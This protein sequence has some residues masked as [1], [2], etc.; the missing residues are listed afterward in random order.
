MLDSIQG[1]SN[2]SPKAFSPL[3]SVKTETLA[4][5]ETTVSLAEIAAQHLSKDNDLRSFKTVHSGGT[6]TLYLGLQDQSSVLFSLLPPS[7]PECSL[8]SPQATISQQ[9]PGVNVDV[10]PE[11][12]QDHSN[13]RSSVIKP[14]TS[15]NMVSLSEV[16]EHLSMDTDLR[17]ESDEN[18]ANSPIFS[19]AI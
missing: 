7:H 9:P 19:E 14:L 1:H 12:F 8:S 17:S 5:P 13:S 4:V 15:V 16:V 6:D 11:L 18:L 2:Y 3:T 10:P